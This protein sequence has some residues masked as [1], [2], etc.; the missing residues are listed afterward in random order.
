[1]NLL[2]D[3]T[4]YQDLLKKSFTSDISHW[5][6]PT[7]KDEDWRYVSLKAVNDQS[8]SL[9]L[10]NPVTI[11]TE[12]K[13]KIELAK[14]QDFTNLVFVNGL[15]NSECSDSLPKGIQL[16][17]AGSQSA[18]IQK[19]FQQHQTYQ[20]IF[21]DLADL[22]EKEGLN[23]TI[24]KGTKQNLNIIY[25]NG[26]F[27]GPAFAA[28]PKNI[29]SI[30]SKAKL[31]CNV[32][33][34]T[35]DQSRYLL[36]PA[37]YF[38]CHDSSCLN[39]YTLQSLSHQ[40]FIFDSY[41]MILDLKSD[42]TTVSVAQG[43]KIS[44]SQIDYIVNDEYTNVRSYGAYQ[45]SDGQNIDFHTWIDHKKGL[46]ISDQVFKGVIGKGGQGV[47][48]GKVKIQKYSQK[49]N[50]AQLNK[51]LLLDSSAEMNSKPELDILADDV[52]AT[53]GATIGQLNADE[54]FYLVSRGI[55]RQ[56]ALE[57]LS[58]G[59]LNEVIEKIDDKKIKDVFFKKIQEGFKTL[60]K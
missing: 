13:Q 33:Y 34:I 47:F 17:S 21:L 48:N 37:F 39:L 24:A 31:N 35:E 44:R 40:S 3:H 50:S 45:A 19:K 58:S 36:A 57:M 23:V 20:N 56:K 53:H 8:F 52:K 5:K 26:N 11:N 7:R 60:S 25:Y 49:V 6:M 28:Y 22:Y 9:N 42:V 4:R 41:R 51:N 29:I 59:F 38:H 32:Q 18:E 55:P 12:V 54:I 10:L 16:L 43:G 30:E 2:I 46:G 14:L 1:M 15:F 27:S